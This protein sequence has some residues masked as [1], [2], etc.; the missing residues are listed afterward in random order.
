MSTSQKSAETSATQSAQHVSAKPAKTQEKKMPVV[1]DAQVATLAS[2]IKYPV[3]NEKAIRLME[4]ENKLTFVVALTATKADIA[5]AIQALYNVKVAKVNTYI[6]VD[7]EKHAYVQFDKAT[8]A[9]DV[10]TALGL[11]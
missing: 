10:A 1:D 3:N 5:Q 2:F 9:I 6:G 4:T 8:P 11:L 7:G